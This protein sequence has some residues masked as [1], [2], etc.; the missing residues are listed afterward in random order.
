LADAAVVSIVDDDKS[1]RDATRRLVRSLGHSA[2]TFASAEEFLESGSLRQTA[3]LIVDVQMP[4][5]SGID[6]QN[7]L[8]ASG[9]CPPVIFVTAF[10][11][12]GVQ[13]RALGAGAVGFLAKPFS[14]ACLIACLDRAL[15]HRRCSDVN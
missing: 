10:P 2:A 8:I 7:H 1:I 5:M 3:C 12:D 6:L 9:D 4:G 13:A 14:E 11:D 15:A